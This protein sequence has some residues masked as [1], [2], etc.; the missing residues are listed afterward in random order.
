MV[1]DVPVGLFLS[2]GYDSSLVASILKESGHQN[3]ETYTIGFENKAYD[4]SNYAKEVADYLGLKNHM[5]YCK[6]QDA[7]EILPYL[8]KYYDEPFAD[9]S[10]IPTI[11]LSKFAAKDVKVVLSADA[12]DETFAGY[13][14]YKRAIEYQNRFSALNKF[15]FTSA[16]LDFAQNFI[17]KNRARIKHN[18]TGLSN[19]IKSPLN[20]GTINYL[21][22]F[23]QKN[24]N[25]L[26]KKLLRDSISIPETY[27]DTLY[28]QLDNKDN[29]INNMLAVDYKTYMADNILTKIDR[30]T[31]SA[32]IEGREPL[33]DHRIIEFAARLPE[34]YKFHNGNQ[35]IIL[36]DICHDYIPE[37]IM[38]RPKQGFTLP[39]YKW[40]RED[41]KDFSMEYL[42]SKRCE[43][44]GILSPPFVDYVKKEFF[45]GNRHYADMAWYIICFNNWVEHWL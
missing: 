7:K 5:L 3:T 19:S 11:L 25:Q 8:P 33:L 45:K 40:L 14:N 29:S 15:R 9:V 36:K 1:S 44:N 34:S 18:L 39:L 17:P 28:N 21:D 20:K 24:S 32:S 10:S 27:F 38:N 43:E 30:A 37:K 4:E 41:L 31:M 26:I 12:G 13:D 23:S 6:T 22:L 42:S 16:G 35:K 2:G